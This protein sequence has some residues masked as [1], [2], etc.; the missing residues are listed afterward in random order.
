LFN[1]AQYRAFA[2]AEGIVPQQALLVK[3]DAAQFCGE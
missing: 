1:R 3:G 2:A